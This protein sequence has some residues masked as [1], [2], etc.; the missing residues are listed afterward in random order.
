MPGISIL[1]SILNIFSR[2]FTS[3]NGRGNRFIVFAIAALALAVCCWSTLFSIPQKF[4]FMADSM[5]FSDVRSI[6]IGENSDIHFHGVPHNY[7]TVTPVEGGGVKWQVAAQHRDTLQY[8]KINNSNPNAHEVRDDAAQKIDIA[9]PVVDSKGADSIVRFSI[10]GAEVWQEWR[11]F[12]KQT[13]VMARH[14]ITRYA[15]GKDGASSADSTLFQRQVIDNLHIRSFFHCEHGTFGGVSAIRLVVLDSA[16]T[17]DGEGYAYSGTVEGRDCKVQFYNV[18]NYCYS[19]GSADAY[20]QIDDVNYV[21]KPLVRLSEW[22]AGHVM[23]RFDGKGA[24]DICFPKGIGYVGSVDSLRQYAEHSSHVVTFRQSS[25]SY[26]TNS[27][28]FLPYFSHNANQDLF[29]LEFSHEGSVLTVRDNHNRAFT[30]GNPSSLLL[31]IPA[32]QKVD[33]TSGSTVVHSRIGNIDT[34][35]MLRYVYQAFLVLLVLLALTLGPW[36]PL[37]NEECRGLYAQDEVD[38]LPSHVAV[39]LFVGFVFCVCKSMIALKLSYSFPYFEKLTVITPFNCAMMLLVFF[40]LM[41][42]L[43]S[44]ITT[45]RGRGCRRFTPNAV[46][47]WVVWG[48]LV[49]MGCGLCLTLF[50]MSDRQIAA[51]VIASYFPREIDFLAKWIDDTAYGTFDNHRTV[52]YSLIVVEALL[53]G[54]LAVLYAAGTAWIDSLTSRV[55][56][57]IVGALPATLRTKAARLWDAVIADEPLPQLARFTARVPKKGGA[58][59]TVAIFWNKA[60]SHVPAVVVLLAFALVFAIFQVSSLLLYAVLALAVLVLFI[61]FVHDALLA[62]LR[63]LFP[64]HFLALLALILIGNIFGNF[65][66]AF[67]TLIV[68]IGFPNALSRVKFTDPARM[69]AAS[70]PRHVVFCEMILISF[71]YMIAAMV[72]DNGYLTNYLGFIMTVLCFYFIRQRPGHRGHKMNEA[73]RNEYKWVRVTLAVVALL[74]VFLPSI[75]GH[76]A[77]PEEVNYSRMSRR[78]MLFSNFSELQ[79]VGYRYAESDSEFMVVMSHYMQMKDGGDPLSND[80]HFLHPSVSTGQSPVVLNDLSMPVAFF[81][82]YGLWATTAVY[83]LLIFG[84]LLLVFHYTFSNVPFRSNVYLTRPMQWRLLAVMMWAGT[85]FYIYFSYLGVLPFTGRLNPGYGVDAVGEALET[86]VLLA[87]MATTT[88]RNPKVSSAA[89]TSNVT[90]TEA[91]I[92]Q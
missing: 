5:T 34:A 74:V 61:D 84:L 43:N 44:R 38:H 67:I 14:L 26:P 3:G 33:L 69:E 11:S 81:G 83:F 58:K 77:D 88:I 76:L 71:I 36:S 40:T 85:S 19:D 28:I 10:S 21:M 63:D 23:L 18:T 55:A 50:G 49:A 39:L 7:I 82:S 92:K 79:K 47:R 37:R 6:T 90:T 52:S 9:I 32:L 89:E 91:P 66:T 73:D 12:R 53:L 17:I 41:L 59:A 20:F 31:L 48:V 30:V 13:D 78:V 62:A 87:F 57:G 42:I 46:S 64:L 54:I 1:E 4:V 51:D 75:C 2:P 45:Y 29:N 80:S 70:L 60:I 27:D 8:F 25:Q 24:A 16:T 86:A 35:F 56:D 22:G 68:I 65:A 72:A 15:L